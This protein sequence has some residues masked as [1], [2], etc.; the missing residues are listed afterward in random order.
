MKNFHSEDELK[1]LF[2]NTSLPSI[3]VKEAVMKK[4][5]AGK[6]SKPNLNTKKRLLL[7]AIIS[8]LLITVGFTALKAWELK[9]P[10]DT[11]YKYEILPSGDSIPSQEI[12]MSEYEKLS[13][14]EA[15]AIMKTKDNPRDTVQ[16]LNKAVIIGN[17]EELYGKLDNQFR[18]PASLPQGYEF[19]EG[20]IG[21]K[22]NDSDIQEIIKDAKVASSDY[23]I[24]K[25]APTKDLSHYSI[26]YRK[27][28]SPIFIN[29]I[30]DYPIK[31]IYDI[32]AG[33]KN[34]IINIKD[35]EAVYIEHD[36][37]GEVAWLEEIDGS[38]TYFS[39]RSGSR[40]K[41]TLTN[42]ILIAESFE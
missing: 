21:Y 8:V 27:D 7:V 15:L 3:E 25:L 38:T 17:L 35:F 18:S 16:I 2:Q 26:T 1:Q 29:V 31:T 33:Q 23:L 10:G 12:Y 13:P 34:Q 6:D 4:L 36:Q 37:F 28:L 30:F 41:N 5:Q 22:Y 14:G 32:N 40:D 19:E 20:S 39:I 24:R 42:L 11:T 9:G